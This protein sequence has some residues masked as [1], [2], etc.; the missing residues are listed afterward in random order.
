MAAQSSAPP[1]GTF[2]L[3]VITPAFAPFSRT[4]QHGDSPLFFRAISA[5]WEAYLNAQSMISR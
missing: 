3:E 4:S 1:F 5:G 2:F